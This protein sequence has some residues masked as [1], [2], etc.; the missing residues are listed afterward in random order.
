MAAA[1]PHV[2]LFPRCFAIH[3]LGGG[4]GSKSKLLIHN[5]YSPRYPAVKIV[6]SKESWDVVE[7]KEG[8]GIAKVMELCIH[9]RGPS[10]DFTKSN[11][12][13]QK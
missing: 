7:Q 11:L 6:L 13:T 4:G 10:D 1:K 2:S 8:E 9:E 12:K 3:I 5:M